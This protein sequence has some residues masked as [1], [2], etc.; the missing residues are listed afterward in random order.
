MRRLALLLLAIPLL[1]QAPPRQRMKPPMATPGAPMAE[2]AV[3]N[4]AEALA[5]ARKGY[6]RDLEVLRHL[7]TAD[8]ALADNMQPENA[9][10]K[11]Y[12]E[13]DAA[14]R[15]NP[16]F[17]TL[18]GVIKAQ[19]ALDSARRSPHS[20]DFGHLRAIVRDE[21]FRPAARQAVQNATRLQ[22]E[23][24]AWLHVQQ[25]IADHLNNLSEITGE[26]LRAAEQ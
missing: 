5:N 4:A 9:I 16:E 3:K 25:L 13:V 12:E 18:Q 14:H 19:D 2:M 17:T 21:A 11:A 24:T 6:D 15:L 23:I 26:S 8:D 10:Q 20:A 7:R 22:S 1:A